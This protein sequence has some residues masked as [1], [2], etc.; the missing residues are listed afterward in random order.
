MYTYS[1][2]RRTMKLKSLNTLSFLE[3]IRHLQEFQGLPLAEWVYKQM[4]D[5]TWHMTDMELK[6]VT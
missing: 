2:M 1:A 6:G 4:L 3:N 5:D